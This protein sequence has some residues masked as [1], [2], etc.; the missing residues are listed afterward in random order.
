M[1][2]CLS[3]SMISGT[4]FAAWSEPGL[5][6]IPTVLMTG[7]Q[8]ELLISFGAKDR[9]I[10]NFRLESEFLYGVSHPV[11]GSPVQRGIADNTAS[12]HL[13]S[14]YFELRL[15]QYNHLPFGLEQGN[16]RRQNQGD[17]NEADVAHQKVDE[18]TDVVERQLA[19]VHILVQDHPRVRAQRPCQL[20]CPDVDRVHPRG[21][22]LQQRVG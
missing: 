14:A 17:G 9:A 4:I 12:S 18:L 2:R 10:H 3:H 20:P 22:G 13:A 1:P 8:Q 5:E 7:I 6:M 21:P 19:G 16:R 15:D 11:A